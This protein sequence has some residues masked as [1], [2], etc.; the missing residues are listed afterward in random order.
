[1][2]LPETQHLTQINIIKGIFLRIILLLFHRTYTPL[3]IILDNVKQSTL[4]KR[5]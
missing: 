4:L 5:V 2:L 1:M 3:A